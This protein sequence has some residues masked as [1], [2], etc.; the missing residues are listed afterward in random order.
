[1]DA[2]RVSPL[3]SPKGNYVQKIYTIKKSPVPQPN[4][5][6]P[7]LKGIMAW[8][9]LDHHTSGPRKVMYGQNFGQ[10]VTLLHSQQRIFQSGMD[11]LA[12]D[13]TFAIRMPVKG[14]IVH[15][16][17]RFAKKVGD[18]QFKS[19]PPQTIIIFQNLER[20][21][22]HDYD[23]GMINLTEYSDLH[24]YL[25]FMYV[26][27]Q[28]LWGEVK[29]GNV[30]DKGYV[31]R[32]TPGV[33]TVTDENGA[34]SR[35]NYKFSLNVPTALLSIPGVAEDGIIIAR[36][37]CKEGEFDTIEQRVVEVGS[38]TF[39][40]NLYGDDE[41]YKIHPDPGEWIASDGVLMALRTYNPNL[42]IA[43]MSVKACQRIDFTFDKK[44]MA[45]GQII[46][47]KVWHDDN[48][49]IPGVPAEMEKS[50]LKVYDKATRE[51]YGSLKQWEER[52][53]REYGREMPLELSPELHHLLVV[54]ESVVYPT[55]P[56]NTNVVK[57]HKKSRLDDYRIEF[58][59]R[60]RVRLN[61]GKKLT[62]FFGGKG[63]VVSVWE[64]EDMPMDQYGR[65]AKMILDPAS[66]N[67]RMIPGR[68]IEM[69]LN[70]A[71]VDVHMELMHRLGVEG[72]MRFHPASKML[73]EMMK[74]DPTRLYDAWEYLMGFYDITAPKQAKVYREG[75]YGANPVTHL[76]TIIA[77]G[78]LT[79]Y[80]R[81]DH[82]LE[83]KD[84]I[85]DIQRLYPPTF[86]PVRYRDDAGNMIETVAPIR[87]APLSMMV[88][89]KLADGWAAVSSAR[90]QHHQ[91]LA[92]LSNSDK[93]SERIRMQP[94]K[95][96]DEATMR[97]VLSFAPPFV[98]V[99]FI[100]RSNNIDARRAILWSIHDAP[101]PSSIAIAV[102]RT[103]IAM[104][105]S[106][107]MQTIHH[108]TICAGWEFVYK[109]YEA[110]NLVP[111][112]VDVQ[113]SYVQMQ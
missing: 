35:K 96:L 11:T 32:D 69:L 97:Q 16:A 30:I 68:L 100:D 1:M 104:D 64:D 51:F 102:D 105:G 53:I 109:P 8:N 26:D 10:A 92:T 43:E 113:P 62:D 46:D 34:S 47:I 13:T 94:T 40:L 108:Q 88:L 74:N 65:R 106:R 101:N 83:S 91:V 76:A 87:I 81:S 37:L 50:Q 111:A 73:G 95:L 78:Q 6:H 89:E 63:V 17:H 56:G 107:T 38:N 25:G 31:F 75:L 99:E 18:N 48:T 27:Q 45:D 82:E 103:K 54:A 24:P 39:P 22:E 23:Y 72:K 98:A 71:A 28:G 110:Q 84:M 15:I 3:W 21:E 59:I 112:S 9:F 42:A 93:Y 49:G 4:E 33:E 57:V 90:M 41:N 55:Y 70:G 7:E 14:K 52:T 66:A 12:A 19:D 77:D 58:T 86:G 61:I 85:A 44:I 80:I 29:I 5:N 36:S 67:N 60:N 20:S 79:V 2:R